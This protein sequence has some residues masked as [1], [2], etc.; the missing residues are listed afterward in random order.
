MV[1]SLDQL[2]WFYR[3]R[4]EQHGLGAE[5]SGNKL[6]YLILA[7]STITGLYVISLRIFQLSRLLF[8]LFILPGNSVC[9][10]R[11]SSDKS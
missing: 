9:D 4:M 11:L 5:T 1:A 7:T 10:I 3:G 6:L 2:G 8:S